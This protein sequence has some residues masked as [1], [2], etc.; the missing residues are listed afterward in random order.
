MLSFHA[1]GRST[2][3][4]SSDARS[5]FSTPG[6][7]PIT[8]LSACNSPDRRGDR[9]GESTA[10]MGEDC[11]GWAIACSNFRGELMIVTTG[12]GRT[13]TVCRKLQESANK[14]CPR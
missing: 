5:E 13:D 1:S 8:S 11:K 7:S 9:G 6:S 2:L 4:V 12:D 14:H 3:L 10:I